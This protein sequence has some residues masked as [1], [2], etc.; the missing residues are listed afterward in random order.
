LG[1]PPLNKKSNILAI[2]CLLCF[3]TVLTL[4]LLLPACGSQSGYT[5]GGG[6]QHKKIRT[7]LILGNSIVQ[8]GPAPAIGWHGNWGMAATVADSDF[9]HILTGYIHQQDSAV[10]VTWKNIGDFE[11]NFTTYPLACLSAFKK[12]DMIVMRIAE[13]VDALKCRDSNFI[14]YCHHLINYLDP[15]GQAVKMM[16]DGFW[17]SPVVNEAIKTYATEKNYPFVSIT[18]LSAD[19]T[20]QAWKNFTHA[21]VSSHPSDKGMRMIAERIWVGIRHFF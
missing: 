7:V 17:H 12:P 14:A 20:N 21:G 8:H 16:V 15:D 4:S 3:S 9:V 5:P 6:K 13:N 19:S 2:L 1:I 18:D 11:R 10:A